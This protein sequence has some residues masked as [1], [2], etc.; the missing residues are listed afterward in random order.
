M[1]HETKSICVFCGASEIV[2]MHYIALA[3]ETGMSIAKRGY[4]LVYGGGGIGLMGA[5]ALSAHHAG[6]DVLGIIPKFLT[7]IEELLTE[8]EHRIV[9][10]MHERKLQMYQESDAFLVLPGGIGTLEEAIEIFSWMRLHLHTKPLVFLDT[11]GYWAPLIALLTHTIDAK[12]TPAWVKGHLF[13]E[14]NVASAL[15]LIEA[16]WDSPAPKGNIQMSDVTGSKSV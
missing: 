15:D 12:F 6:G 11:D 3:E 4:R 10:D 8:I 2:D 13:R 5:S 14:T 9:D 7:E 1:P 16:Q